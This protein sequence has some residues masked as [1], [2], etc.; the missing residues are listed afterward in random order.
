M[1]NARTLCEYIIPACPQ[2]LEE[3]QAQLRRAEARAAE[4]AAAA[5]QYNDGSAAAVAHKAAEAAAMLRRRVDG[6]QALQADS[7]PEVSC[8]AHQQRLQTA[9]CDGALCIAGLECR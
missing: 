1:C 2:A 8:Y 6:P 4:S 7:A 5:A 3:E 9:A